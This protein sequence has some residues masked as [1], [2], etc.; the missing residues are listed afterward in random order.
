MTDVH[1]GTFT[2]I[3]DVFGG[4]KSCFPKH[5]EC[6]FIKTQM[7]KDDEISFAT[8]KASV[9]KFKIV[10]VGDQG[11]G[12]SSIISRFIK[13]EFDQSHN[14]KKLVRTADSWHRFRLEEPVYQR[15]DSQIAIVG[16]GRTRKI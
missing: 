14:V 13:N 12:K 3:D 15:Q 8:G 10:F 11:V 2:Q 6:I 7:K 4:C 9:T 16:Y 5:P 1:I